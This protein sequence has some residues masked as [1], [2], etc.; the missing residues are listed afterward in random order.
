MNE[1][2]MRIRESSQ[3]MAMIVNIITDISDR[4]NLL[5]LNAAI[6]AARAGDAGRGFAV[7][8]DEISKLADNTASSVKEIV[9]LI[10]VTEEDVQKGNEMVSET[11]KR[12]SGIIAGIADIR[13]MVEEVTGSA[14]KQT[15]VNSRIRSDLS[16]VQIRTE[17]IG[18]SSSEQKIALDEVTI[19]MNRINELSQTISAGSE[20]I[21]AAM[22]ENARISDTL[23]GRVGMFRV[24]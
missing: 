17:Q 20:E 9:S 22:K 1:S 12:I 8:A 5:S 6:E 10:H 19:G 2:I 14:Q 7:V 24:K 18:H 3:K 23:R 4:I 11:V 21:A 13:L 15:A 16:H